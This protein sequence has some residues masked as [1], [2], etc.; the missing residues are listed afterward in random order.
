V[1]MMG[2]TGFPTETVDEALE[3]VAFLE[4]HGD[5]WTVAGLGDFILT[6]GAIIAMKPADFGIVEHGPF[7][8]DDIARILHFREAVS[9]SVD[10]R[11]RIR[12][13]KG[14]L[15]RQNFDRP[16]AG[17]IDAPHSMFYYDR[18]ATAFPK[19]I[20]D[21]FERDRA[22]VGDVPLLLNGRII[23]DVRFDPWRCVDSAAVPELRMRI[24]RDERRVLNAA[25]IAARVDAGHP[26]L[27]RFALPTTYF[28]RNDGASFPLSRDLYEVLRAI[29]GGERLETAIATASGR[30]D[31]DSAYI[32]FAATLVAASGMVIPA[33]RE[34]LA[35]AHSLNA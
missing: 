33:A 24:G 18:Y 11:D 31:T 32:A 4:R 20:V 7:S 25:E 30:Q 28:L 3:S 6:P 23:D 22:Q 14:R 10:D 15:K 8:N 21:D 5:K 35:G 17:G 13:A 16:F 29:E 2:F 26:P 9:I 34:L 1:Q 19:R 27:E 12:A